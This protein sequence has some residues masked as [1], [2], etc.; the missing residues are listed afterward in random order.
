MINKMHLIYD[1][2]GDFKIKSI[3]ICTV[4]NMKTSETV[5]NLKYKYRICFKKEKNNF[6]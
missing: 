1:L 6:S 2:A 3:F 5:P 4:F